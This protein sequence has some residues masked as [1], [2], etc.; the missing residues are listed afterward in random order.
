MVQLAVQICLV[1]AIVATVRG[2][3]S[4]GADSTGEQEEEES[5][6]D[7]R[8]SVASMAAMAETVNVLTTYLNRLVPFLLGLFISLCLRRW[9]T[10]RTAY[11]QKVFSCGAQL[12]FW[13][14][15]ALPE[16]AS[17]VGKRVERDFLLAHKLVYLAAG[18]TREADMLKQLLE[19]GHLTASEVRRLDRRV[20]M[21]PE[22]MKVP[23]GV[24]DFAFAMLPFFWSAH[25]I[26]RVFLFGNKTGGVHGVSLPPPVLVKMLSYCMD[27]RQGVENIS[28][29]LAAPLPFPY[30]HLVCLLVHLSALFQCLQSGLALAAEPVLGVQRIV[31]ELV[32]LL[33]MNSLYCGLLCLAVVLW[34]PFGDDIVDLPQRLLHHQLWKSQAY[35]T[36]FLDDND[37]LDSMLS[38]SFG[39][40]RQGPA[41]KKTYCGD[42][43]DDDEEGSGDDDEGDAG[44]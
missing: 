8:L 20:N 1:F 17:W 16:K 19:E 24:Y 39:G 9:W 2:D 10:I 7:R 43:H 30:V 22:T 13:L 38:E 40:R 26:Y 4:F 25:L 41:G 5:S 37:L 32:L 3:E 14:R 28:M 15:I 6:G 44:D 29:V 23:D 12:S 31:F 34:N 33:A 36:H 42:E 18:R 27:A 21:L 11:L 35:A